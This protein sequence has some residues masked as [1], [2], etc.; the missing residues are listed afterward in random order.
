MES[1][2]LLV[3]RPIDRDINVGTA[4][5]AAYW[6]LRSE[7]VI[8][9][10]YPVEEDYWVAAMEYADSVGVDLV[11]TSL[12]YIEYEWPFTSYKYEDMDGR[13]AMPTRAANIAS[14]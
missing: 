10:D 7:D 12:S 8:S 3:W 14:R 9:G 5:D 13:T 1:V 6:L 4:P 2:L 11:N